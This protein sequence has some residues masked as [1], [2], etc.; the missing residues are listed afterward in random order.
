MSLFLPTDI[1]EIIDRIGGDAAMLSGKRVLLAGGGGFLGRYFVE[2]F[3]RLNGFVLDKPCQITVLDSFITSESGDRQADDANFEFVEHDIVQPLDV[4]GTYDYVVHAAGIAS[5]Y[6]YRA[7]PLQALEVST[8][9]CRNLLELAKRDDARFV[10]FSSSEVYGDPDPK[11]VPMAESYRGNVATAGPRACYDEG[12]RAGETMCHI[13]HDSFGVHTNCIRPFNVYGPG[14]SETDYR[15]LPNFASCIAGD[16]PVNIYGSGNQTRTY[17][18]ITD[19]IVGFSL[20]MLKGVAGAIYNIGAP[21]PEVSVE[22]LL[23]QMES[24]LGRS[25]ARQSVEYPDSYPGDE[26]QRRCPDIRKAHLQLGYSA[27]V[28]LAEGLKRFLDWTAD[29]YTGDA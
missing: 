5:P 23:D 21:E 6:Y 16:R 22:K 7:Y 10:F 13:F 20:V 28:A 17:C 1:E 2:T 19:A 27:E 15:V 4:D 8:I 9:G 24:A 3:R 18:Y 11:H 14:M 29:H 12:K 26:P 25:I